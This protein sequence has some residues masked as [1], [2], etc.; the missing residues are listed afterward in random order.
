MVVDASFSAFTGEGKV[1]GRRK[2]KVTAEAG[3][4]APNVI[5][6]GPDLD[7]KIGKIVFTRA[8]PVASSANGNGISFEAFKGT[9]NT[10]KQR[11]KK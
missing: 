8:I 2:K 10:I 4:A 3:A 5:V 6:R 11:K 7:F 9:G 1:L